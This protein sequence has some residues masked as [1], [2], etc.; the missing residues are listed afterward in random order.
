MSTW[1]QDGDSWKS[2]D[3]TIYA[4]DARCTHYTTLKLMGSDRRARYMLVEAGEVIAL[5]STL[6]EAKHFAAT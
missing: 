5:F 1:Q 3:F 4:F 2:G 6:G